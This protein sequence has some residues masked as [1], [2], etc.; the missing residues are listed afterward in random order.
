MSTRVGDELRQEAEKYQR[1]DDSSA[2]DKIVAKLREEIPNGGRS[3][4]LEYLLNESI[5]K[6]L[7]TD[8]L[9]VFYG[10]HTH[11]CECSICNCCKYHP[12]KPTMVSIDNWKP[13][14]NNQYTWR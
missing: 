1:T 10:L 13:G 3:I 6:L 11:G 14:N 2:F 8:G 4:R 12:Q 7:R 5:A 9:Y